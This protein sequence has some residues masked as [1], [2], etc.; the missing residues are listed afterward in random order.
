MV[1]ALEALDAGGATTIR[2][3]A[4][5]LGRPLYEQLGFVPEYSL[6]RYSGIPRRGEK[7]SKVAAYGPD[8]EA[9]ILSLDQAA[10]ATDR[11]LLLRR[12]LA[13]QPDSVRVATQAGR[14]AGYLASRQGKRAVQIG[15]CIAESVAGRALLA[16]AWRRFSDQRVYVDVPDGNALAVS[17]VAQAG[18]TVERPFVRMCRG[19][20]LADDVSRLWAC[21]GPEKG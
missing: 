14:M 2:L 16:D 21:F 11:G 19:T 1:Q 4:T 17:E 15:P 3:D 9:G 8:Q 18:L 6:C 12:L 13:E 20:R 7:D 5:P 10:T